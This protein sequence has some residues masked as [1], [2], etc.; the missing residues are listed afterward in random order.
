MSWFSSLK[1][2]SLK[3]AQ[4]YKNEFS[5]FVSNLNEDMGTL[6]GKSENSPEK[7]KQLEIIEADTP[8]SIGETLEED[9]DFNT[10]P[11]PLLEILRNYISRDLTEIELNEKIAIV[12]SN[13]DKFLQFDPVNFTVPHRSDFTCFEDFSEQKSLDSGYNQRLLGS[14]P[15]SSIL[16]VED[17]EV[18][19]ASMEQTTKVLFY[20]LI[21]SLIYLIEVT[22][23][24]NLPPLQQKNE[25]ELL[26]SADE[27]ALDNLNNVGDKKSETS[28]QFV[29]VEDGSSCSHRSSHETEKIES[30]G[31]RDNSHL[32]ESDDWQV[33]DKAL[34]VDSFN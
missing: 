21:Y 16:N 17:F 10:N 31:Q 3:L 7:G 12:L 8:G 18:Q 5:E 15:I 32:S 34:S 9:E 28:E 26:P 14:I 19:G 1:E 20:R 2:K 4:I 23:F 33:E 24:L 11:N 25:A 6:I 29:M 27:A 30:V 13:L 22:P